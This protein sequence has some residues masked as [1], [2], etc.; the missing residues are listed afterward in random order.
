MDWSA[1]AKQCNQVTD[2]TTTLNSLLSEFQDIFQAPDS[3][4]IIKNFKA[5]IIL[6]D[7]D[8]PKLLKAR[9][10]PYAV[11]H[12]VEAEL[13][14]MEKTG[15]LEKIDLSNWASPLV[16]VP[17]SNGK[18]RITGD[19]K[20]TVNSQLHIT[21]YPLALPEDLFNSISHGEKF[22]KLD[23]TNAYH[24]MKVQDECKNFL[25][26]N[27]HKGL[28]RY[29]VLPQGIASSPAIFQEF[30]DQMLRDIPNAGSFIDDYIAT[31]SSDADHLNTLRKIFLKM[32]D[33]NYKLS[34]EKCEF[35][36]SSIEFLGHVISKKG[37]ETSPKKVA[38]IQSIPTPRDVH[39]VSSFLGFINFYGKFIPSLA[40]IAEPLYKLTRT[41]VKWSWTK[42]CQN[43]FREIKHKLSSSTVL[44][45]FN[46]NLP[47]GI[48]CDSSSIGVGIVL[49]HVYPD[50]T[51]RPIFYASK[52]LN[53]T[54]R[55]YSQVEKEGFAIIYGL[56]KFYKYLCGRKF[57][58]ITDHKPLLTIF[59]PKMQLPVYVATRLHHWSLFLSQF[60]YDVFYRKSEHHGNA[61][62]LSR[63]RQ[64]ADRASTAV[65]SQV[66]QV[67]SEQ[68][69]VIPV[70]ANE[71]QKETVRDPVLCQVMQLMTS[72][73]PQ[74]LSQDAPALQPFFTRRA[75]LTVVNGLLMLG[76]RVIIPVR[77]RKRL[78]QQLHET[79][80]GIV[81]MKTLARAYVYWPSIDFDI[82]E[83]CKSCVL[84]QSNKPDPASAPL[85]PW[86]YPDKPMQRI[87]MDLAGPLH[88]RMW[89]VIVDAHSK[90]PEVFSMN[91]NTTTAAVITKLSEVISRFGI[92]HQIVTDNGR[93]F[94][95]V[96][97][98][99]FCKRNG[100]K[101]TLSSPYHPRSNGEAERFVKTFKEGMKSAD[102]QVD[103]HLSRFLFTY[104]VTPHS[105]T[106]QSPAELLQ[107]RKLRNQLDLVRPDLK[108][109]VEAKQAKQKHDYDKHTKQRTFN[110]DQDVWVRTFSKNEEKW[111]KGKIAQ[112]LGPVTYMVIVN[113]K[114]I[115]R[116]VDHIRNALQ[117][118]TLPVGTEE[119]P[120]PPP[121]SSSQ[122]SPPK[123][124]A[125]ARRNPARNARH[126]QTYEK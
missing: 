28:Y 80:I 14:F 123:Q 12:K 13:D 117:E 59:G 112:A 47:I 2:A 26:I 27:T 56:K 31:G 66:N 114:N 122:D 97:F 93:Q 20:N 63:L 8:V 60:Q 105:T 124:P 5:R 34:K 78:L 18:V 58:L 119:S 87:H 35:M 103:I 107:G 24:Q 4:S 74:K 52:I 71:I 64:N 57:I 73:W 108:G 55:R 30:M 86:E 46:P 16:V 51:E 39:D 29:N 69:E 9:T 101:Q 90:W 116:H 120:S 72:G 98:G 41:G 75:E 82:E 23:G 94:A 95:S 11:R 85:H 104:R 50:G 121:P 91:N 96:E 54:E 99:E 32:R 62:A 15:V 38:D 68:L 106:G 102:T 22:S 76:M 7:D 48:S 37:I 109:H 89:L 84:C 40:D 79:H 3:G 43:A 113:G 6:K 77:L 88:G 118:A 36:K 65:E 100:I 81:K 92:P 42:S 83:A 49:Y 10:L 19:F 70:T 33:C 17:K 126:T 1:I 125:P 45:H 115:K 110:P 61:D 25:V 44:A 111:S 67:V 53:E 21:Q